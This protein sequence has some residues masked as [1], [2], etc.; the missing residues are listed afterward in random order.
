MMQGDFASVAGTLAT[1]N[2]IMTV[3]SGTN[4]AV[5]RNG[6]FSENFIYTNPQFAGVTINGNN[7]HAN[8]HSMQAQVTMRPT[9]GL[10]FQTTYTWA[11]NLGMSGSGNPFDRAAGYYLAGQHRSHQLT[12]FGTYTLPMGANGFIFRNSTGILKKA[13]EGW[14]L[15]WTSSMTSG[16]PG[17]ITGVNRLWGANN[18]DFVGPKGSWDNKAGTVTWEPGAYQG[19]FFG[20]KYVRVMDPQCYHVASSLYS[21]CSGS[22]GLKALALASDPSVI[23]FQNPE[24]GK[25]GN[26]GLNE[27]AGPGRWSLDMAIGKQI[28]FMEGKT[29]DFRVDAQNIFNHPTPSGG[30]PYAWNA[31]FTQIYNPEF[32]LNSTTNF[33]QLNSK[34]G[35]RTWQAKIR[36]GF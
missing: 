33:G 2:G 16:L 12:S 10:S 18:V 25:R 21:A 27:L 23:V 19:Y 13:V 6:G 9:R 30:S 15:S 20:N 4:G 5:L 34:G 28:E 35:H 32:G 3:A 31:R 11:R 17:S 1:T 24:L 36:I 22:S 29:I 26:F 14:Q 8:Y 7:N